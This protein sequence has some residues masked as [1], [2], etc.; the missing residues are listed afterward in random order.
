M[1]HHLIKQPREVV[2]LIKHEGPCGQHP[3]EEVA[4]DAGVVRITGERGVDGSL[5]GGVVA[6]EGVG[7]GQP[8]VGD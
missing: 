5:H 7:A 2:E 1:L 8:Q 6:A 3:T 4:E